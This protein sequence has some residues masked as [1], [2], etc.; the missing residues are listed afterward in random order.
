MAVSVRIE[1]GQVK[2]PILK[3]MFKIVSCSTENPKEEATVKL[4]T[5]EDF[6]VI[7]RISVVAFTVRILLR[8]TGKVLQFILARVS[9]F[10]LLVFLI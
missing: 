10:C 9:D 8:V 1:L 7:Q 2:Q 6:G 3:L 4:P 5:E